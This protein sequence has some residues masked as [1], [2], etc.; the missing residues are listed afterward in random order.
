M[1]STAPAPATST[2]THGLASTTPATPPASAPPR[3]IATPTLDAAFV[4]RLAE[5]VMRR[6]EKRV[7]VER[8]R[9]GL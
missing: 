5:D 9:R 2:T 1:A 4:D 8:E 6:V 3:T 7:R